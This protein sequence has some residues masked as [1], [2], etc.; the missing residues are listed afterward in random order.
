[1]RYAVFIYP[2]FMGLLTSSVLDFVLCAVP[3]LVVMFYVER[4]RPFDVFIFT[5]KHADLA[6]KFADHMLD[7]SEEYDNARIF[8]VDPERLRDELDKG[9]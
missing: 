8:F 9:A 2:V 4:P 3:L 7:E 1:M 5:H 6:D